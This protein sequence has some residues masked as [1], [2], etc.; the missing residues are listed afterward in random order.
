MINRRKSSDIRETMS[1]GDIDEMYY[2][3]TEL[4]TAY[5]NYKKIQVNLVC[6]S[7]V[8]HEELIHE[9]EE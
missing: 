9:V 1:T 3:T 8:E 5:H 7:L 6:K 2:D 4:E